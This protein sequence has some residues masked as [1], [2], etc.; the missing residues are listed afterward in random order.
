[1]NTTARLVLLVNLA[2]IVGLTVL[3]PAPMLA[4]GAMIVG[5]E[6]LAADCFA[7]HEPF[8]GASSERCTTCHVVADIGLR[9]V[10]GADAAPEP[11]AIAF[12]QELREPACVSCHS[13]HAG[14]LRY[15]ESRRFSHELLKASAVEECSSCHL[16]PDD[17]LHA[18]TSAPC[19]AC[20]SVEGWTPATFEH[21]RLS[22]RERAACVSCHLSHRPS[23]GL[24]RKVGDACGECHTTSAWKPATF[25]HAES[26]VLDRD[27]D[28][29]CSTC[30]T[31]SDYAQYTCYGCHEHSER[32]VRAEHEEEGIRDFQDC[33]EC[34]RSADEHEAE[35]RGRG[36]GREGRGGEGE[37]D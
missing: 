1:M 37:D 13:D 8:A 10:A 17:G 21:E 16:R 23:D 28:V 35:G 4:P 20:H 15:R 3:L 18:S 29:E 19:G 31:T 22:E 27:H 36:G 14:V 25:D 24:H 26:F 11:G 33:V 30:H 6:Q 32:G 7:C 2:A 9:T 34:H 5:H 12:H